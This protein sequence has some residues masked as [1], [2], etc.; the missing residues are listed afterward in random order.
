M[1][2]EVEIRERPLPRMHY[3]R[4]GRPY[5]ATSPRE[6]NARPRVYVHVK[7]E[8]VLENFAKRFDRPIT[9]YREAAKLGLEKLNISGK[10]RWSQKAGCSC[11]CSP[12]FI[13]KEQGGDG[14]PVKPFDIWVSI[15]DSEPEPLTERGAARLQALADDPTMPV[16]ASPGRGPNGKL[17]NFAAMSEEKLG[18]VISDLMSFGRDPEA[19]SAALKVE[20]K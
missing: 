3:P 19:L 15:V 13:L 18:R 7:D 9:L 12:G 11:G 8:S 2:V 5:W 17:R 14:L 6:Y 16:S 4:Y 20:V 1:K 10:L